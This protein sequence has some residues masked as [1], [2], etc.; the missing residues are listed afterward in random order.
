MDKYGK[1]NYNYLPEHNRTYIRDQNPSFSSSLLDQIY[2]SIDETNDHKGT[3]KPVKKKKQFVHPAEDG[4]DFQRI[5]N[6]MEKR[7]GSEKITKTTSEKSGASTD[8]MYSRKI[9]EKYGSFVKLNSS[10]S[11]SDS[12]SGGL[13][14]SEAESNYGAS[15]RS[16]S[17][18]TCKPKPVKTSTDIDKILRDEV[19]DHDSGSV[20]KRSKLKALK[21]YGD[22]K[23][24]KQPISPGAK[25]ASFLNSLFT[26]GGGN[27][28]KGK[29]PGVH[30][31]SLNSSP[32]CST[33][34]SC[35]S[36][37][38][39]KLSNNGTKRSVR[40]YPVSVI[41]DQDCQPCGH[42]SL[43]HGH[44]VKNIAVSD[45]KN[46]INEEVMYH[47][48]RKDQSVEEAAREL[49]KS[50]QRKVECQMQVEDEDDDDDDASYASSDLFELDNL[51]N[52]NYGIDVS[53]N[54]MEE[55]PVYETTYLDT[56]R[57]IA[58]SLFV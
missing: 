28:K 45:N 40:F 34:R 5:E 18:S 10:W 9:G 54:Y 19:R 4:A 56:N 2:R 43:Q 26:T 22:L 12:S 31:D 16:S 20:V 36:K 30:H 51:N 42:K 3:V 23:K 29:T 52:E 7:K 57:A 13:F 8:H 14:S 41:V 6:W 38:P 39:G 1:H 17:T 35:L 58:N 15:S 48:R 25:L 24:A 33:S 32:A 55:L 53:G 50:Y 44:G 11:S 47:M 21:I 27:A 46:C 37:S 49:L